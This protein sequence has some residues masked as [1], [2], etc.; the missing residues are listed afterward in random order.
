M[1]VGDAAFAVRVPELERVIA[2]CRGAGPGALVVG[3]A[4]LGKTTLARDAAAQWVEDG[5]RVIWI[6]AT[7]SSRRF[8]FGALVGVAAELDPADFIGSARSFLDSVNESDGVLLVVDDAHLLDPASATLVHR[9][10]LMPER[11]AL[12]VTLDGSQT[13]PDAVGHLGKDR[14]L[15]VVEIGPLSR[16]TTT[17]LLASILAGHVERPTCDRLFELSGGNPFV[18]H[19]L[20]A[21]GVSSGVLAE[22]NGAWSWRGGVPDHPRLRDLVT[23]RLERAAPPVQWMLEILCLSEPLSLEQLCDAVGSEVVAAGEA[24]SLIVVER[25]VGLSEVRFPHVLYAQV[26][27]ASLGK[28][29]TLQAFRLLDK[30]LGNFPGA[31]CGRSA[32]A[33]GDTARDG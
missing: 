14:L 8:T 19:E 18:L 27:R 30:V 16:E 12:L 29:R 33:G 15:E 24:A 21:V 7:E 5:G 9:L 28:V 10:A 6:G 32:E 11:L 1:A 22:K 31:K 3:E 26:V 13:P 2:A 17:T 25:Q 23:L 4:G 20:V